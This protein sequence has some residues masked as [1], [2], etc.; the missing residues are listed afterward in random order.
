MTPLT[1]ALMNTDWSPIC[2]IF[3]LLGRIILDLDQFLLDAVDDRQ[4]R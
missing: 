2:A 1:A 3:R 4:R